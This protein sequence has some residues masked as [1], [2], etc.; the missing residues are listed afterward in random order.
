MVYA[1]F[2]T[3]GEAGYC[4][5]FSQGKIKLIP[6][7]GDMY[8]LEDSLLFG[9]FFVEIDQIVYISD[10][11]IHIYCSEVK[12]DFAANP[13]YYGTKDNKGSLAAHSFDQ[14]NDFPKRY[15][16]EKPKGFWSDMIAKNRE[17]KTKE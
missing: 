5:S 12:P 11:I 16:I 1:L 8:L 6:S 9:P 7:P 14:I 10:K 17:T 13:P 15:G 4:D 2:Y 3:F